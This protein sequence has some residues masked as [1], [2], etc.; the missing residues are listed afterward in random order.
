ML[1][2]GV[3]GLGRIQQE[4]DKLRENNPSAATAIETAI[5]VA[6]GGPLKAAVGQAV[7]YGIEQTLGDSISQVTNQITEYAAS[8]V[9][10]TDL[11]EFRDGTA[12]ERDTGDLG[13][14]GVSY[15]GTQDG[16]RLGATLLGIGAGAKSVKGVGKKSGDEYPVIQTPYGTATQSK[17]PEA[18][19][20]RQSIEDGAVLNRGGTL[21]QSHAGEGQFWST[22]NPLSPGYAERNGIPAKN[23][24]PDFICS[25]T[26]CNGAPFIT[27]EAPGVGKNQGG[28]IEVVTEPGGVKLNYFHATEK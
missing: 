10:N 4:I 16:I 25:G 24:P 2:V 12:Y 22:D 28:S 20:V 8:L 21:G 18:L 13:D 15:T 1:Q 5:N 11:A 26:L 6:T 9:Q 27:R 19:A 23:Y 17:T 3:D 7:N 14:L